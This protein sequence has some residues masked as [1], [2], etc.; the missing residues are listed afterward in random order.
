MPPPPR[1]PLPKKKGKAPSGPT[2][3]QVRARKRGALMGLCLGDALGVRTDGKQLPAPSFPEAAESPED[4][5][6]GGGPHKLRQGQVSDEGQV[7]A[8]LG[9]VLMSLH[10]YD[11]VE[12]GKAYARWLPHAFDVHPTMKAA[13]ELIAEGRDPEHTGRRVW[14]ESHQRAASA[15]SLARAGVLG[16]FLWKDQ[17]ARLQATLQDAAITHFE[18]RCQ[19]AGVILNAALAACI[20]SP[21]D[22]VE[23]AAV[24]KQIEADLSIAAAELGRTQPEWVVQVKDASDWLR[25]DLAAAQDRDP[26]LYGPDLHLW[27]HAGE[28]RVALRLALWELFHAS[29]ARSGLLDVINR[30]GDADANGAIAGVL[31]GARFGEAAWP[32]DW[33]EA[34]F[35][36]PVGLWAQGP[37]WTKYH[38]SKLLPLVDREPGTPV[39]VEE[40][41]YS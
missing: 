25:E 32:E 9:E 10:R 15:G 20:A 16:T 35:G 28:V 30:G 40:N 8:A 11:L 33:C 41:R 39:P 31:L 26:M 6:R 2:P 36:E 24:L 18:P 3:E 22:E 13:L 19:L 34:V 14:L 27:Q 37:L 7:A 4:F 17:K 29:S 1:P 38:P 5:P 23:P 21:K 12:A